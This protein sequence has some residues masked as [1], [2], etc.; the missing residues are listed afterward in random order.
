[1][2]GLIQHIEV[3]LIP[4]DSISM[5]ALTI[6]FMPVIT[7]V[8]LFFTG[9][10]ILASIRSWLATGVMGVM[11]LLSVY[12]HILLEGEHIS[13]WI[14]FEIGTIKF[15]TSMLLNSY[16]TTMMVIATFV[17]FMVHLYSLEYMRERRNHTKYFP[18]LALFVSSMLGIIL[19]DNL[20]IT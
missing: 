10:H 7:F 12:L 2:N 15:T 1:M 3:P 4:A 16:S 19:S 6:F 11:F 20:L 8:I 18:Y 17:S 14:W 5:L 9:K 13:R